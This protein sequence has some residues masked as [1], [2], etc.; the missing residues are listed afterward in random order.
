MMPTQTLVRYAIFFGLGYTASVVLIGIGER[1]HRFLRGTRPVHHQR[2]S[3][4]S[5]SAAGVASPIT[6]QRKGKNH[7]VIKQAFA[8]VTEA[9]RRVTVAVLDKN[10]QLALGT[11]IDADGWVATKASQI[12]PKDLTCLLHNGTRLHA[13]YVMRDIGRDL[14]LLRVE[15]DRPLETPNWRLDA[16]EVG[17][18]LATP[19][20]AEWPV[21]I[22]IVSVELIDIKRHPGVLGIEMGGGEPG[23][24]IHR[25]MRASAAETA[26]LQRN[27]VILSVDGV[28][29][30]TTHE[31]SDTIARR[32][33]GDKIELEI[34]RDERKIRLPITLGRKDDL[35]LVNRDFQYE[36]GGPL[37]TRRSGFGKVIQHDTVLAPEQCGGP[38]VDVK[39]RVVGINI[40]RAERVSSY[41]LPATVVQE[42]VQ[43]LK[44]QTERTVSKR[45]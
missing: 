2:V 9:G 22:G 45:E 28:P 35:D 42:V 4:A 21:A 38:L 25:V 32:W 20:T 18:L 17:S 14:A 8:S 1:H 26:G 23:P 15:S 10:Q 29:V 36:L 5:E 11:V 6:S 37:S 16:P 19:G 43:Q 3:T 30:S 13:K 31:L 41:A 39:G 12:P 27:D 44:R 33:P 7:D 34:K 40:A 24:F